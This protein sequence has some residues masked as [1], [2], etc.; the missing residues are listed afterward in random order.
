M[1]DG[2]NYDK[3]IIKCKCL[4]DSYGFLASLLVKALLSQNLGGI[5]FIPIVNDAAI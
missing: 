2:R 1:F 4:I 3:E 5:L